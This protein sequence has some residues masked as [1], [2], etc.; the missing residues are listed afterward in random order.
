M[1]SS[2]ENS[3][4]RISIIASVFTAACAAL[5][6]LGWTLSI[7]ALTSFLPG[8]VA[9]NPATAVLFLLVA[10][11]LALRAQEQSARFH[12]PVR[13]IGGVIL[14]A[15]FS[16]LLGFVLGWE[17]GIDRVLFAA[18]L[19]ENRMAPNTAFCFALLGIAIV[20]LDIRILRHWPSQL[21]SLTVMTVA[22][23]SILG[24]AYGAQN[25]YGIGSYIPM[26]ANTALLLL[27]TGFGLLVIKRDGIAAIF[28]GAE[29]G[30]AMVRRLLPTAIVVP[31]LLGLLRIQ[32]QRAG[33]Y[34]TEFGA[35]LM[36]VAT[37]LL[38]IA[39]IVS[40]ARTLN[41]TDA[42]RLRNVEA[43]RVTHA[44]LQTQTQVLQSILNSMAD[45]VIVA[46]AQGGFMQFN[47]AAQ[48][49]L[50]F[51][52]ND[53]EQQGWDSHCSFF[54]SDGLTSCP[55]DELPLACAVRGQAVTEQELYVRNNKRGAGTWISISARPLRNADGS[56]Q[57]GIV[58][59][60]DVSERKR[61][62]AALR[63]S[64]QELER[65]VNLRTKEL[66]DANEDLSQKNQENE[67]FVYS[68][69]HD[70]RS[71]L[72][73]LQ[74]FSKE[75]G[76]L[77]TELRALLTAENVPEPVKDKAIALLDGDV[78]QSLRFIQLAVVRLGNI[79][80]ALLR[81]SR[82]GRVEYH[83]GRIDLQSS[84]TR[85]AES[86]AAGTTDEDI[87][88]SV[89]SLTPC[90]GDA[91][92]VEQIF[93]NLI[94]NAVKYRDK[95]RSTIIEIGELISNDGLTG[96]LA[97]YYVRDNGLGIPEAHQQKIFQAFKRAH[98]SVAAGDGIGLAIVRR[99][100]E[101]HGGT[102]WVESKVGQGSTFYVTLPRAP[103]GVAGVRTSEASQG[104]LIRK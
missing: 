46:D 33:W 51:T 96:S 93:A 85:L 12:G 69:S 14:A 11:G 58:V 45:G 75:L 40:T 5:V 19:G 16:L 91:T 15:A 8:L 24:Y 68:V 95:S 13:I 99:T 73:N 20:T 84:V 49:I 39:A 101:R 37:V 44:E 34:D 26:A 23:I 29:S 89:Q 102:A 22:L 4:R 56:L 78:K 82:V 1:P 43:L 55:A 79:I 9:M 90:V 70:L 30:S 47:P 98:P 50:G 54:A 87:N 3:L 32:G 81:L 104:E 35:A 77:S 48:R 86:I 27:T 97:T 76:V 71:P 67:M 88:I 42:E 25:L 10:A 31:C 83:S 74:G 63:D 100:A 65:R 92:A 2:Q 18:D 52:A 21:M 6:L 38:L 72:V 62:E 7:P 66:A 28:Y 103:Q 61:A 57:G 60:R 36:V 94:G 53:V 17:T 59:F 80:D 64:H 41:R